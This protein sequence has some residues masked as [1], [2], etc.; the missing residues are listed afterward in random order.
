MLSFGWLTTDFSNLG[1]LSARWPETSCFVDLSPAKP[2][3]FSRNPV[4]GQAL[5]NTLDLLTI[6]TNTS[7]K[8]RTLSVYRMSDGMKTSSQQIER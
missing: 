8:S 3:I 6:L 1:D 5:L 4:F 2:L 7:G